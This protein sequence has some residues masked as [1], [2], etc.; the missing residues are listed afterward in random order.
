M[1]WVAATWS[2]HVSGHFG[3]ALLDPLGKASSFPEGVLVSP[4]MV[5]VSHNTVY[6][7]VV[8]VAETSVTLQPHQPLQPVF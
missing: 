7:P 8:N 2:S 5:T 1:K 6:V 4:A 3:E